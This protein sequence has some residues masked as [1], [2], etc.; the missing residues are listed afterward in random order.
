MLGQMASRDEQAALL[1]LVHAGKAPWHAVADLVEAAG[2]AAAVMRGE[3]ETDDP[4]DIALLNQVRTLTGNTEVERWA[5]VLDKLAK[6]DPD[7][8]LVTV[9][10]DAYPPNLRLVYNRP[11]FLFIR[12]HLQ[13]QD[14]RAVAIVG[15]RKATP[16]GLEEA[17]QL[18]AALSHQGVTIISGLAKGIDS[19][20]HDSTLTASGRTL[21]VIGTGILNTYPP[22]NADLAQRIVASGGALISQFTPDGPPRATNFP[23]RN[24]V[25]SGMAIGTVVI[26]ASATSGARMQA[27][28]ALEHGKRLFLVESLVMHQEWAKRYASRPGAVVVRRANDVLDILASSAKPIQQLVIA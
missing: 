28:L 20:A 17:R 22:E 18:A 7:V 26:E 19:A 27:R 9:L 12:G 10:D 25:T 6:T 21:A 8:E 13:P 16:A 4:S 14:Q 11:P 3:V 5:A 2:S 15:T 1:A 24:V 23:L